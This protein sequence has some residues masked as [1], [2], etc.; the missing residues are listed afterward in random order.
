MRRLA[1]VWGAALHR[2]A[3]MHWFGG[4]GGSLGAPGVARAAVP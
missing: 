2:G 3:R 1:P 4:P